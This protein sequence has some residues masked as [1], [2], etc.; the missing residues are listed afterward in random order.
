MGRSRPD[1]EGCLQ[2]D[3]KILIHGPAGATDK[4]SRS[5]GLQLR[6]A[7]HCVSEDIE[8]SFVKPG[9]GCV[10]KH[11][12]CDAPLSLEE[13]LHRFGDAQYRG[14]QQPGM[15]TGFGLPGD[16]ACPWSKTL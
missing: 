8:V 5:K 9:W 4:Q 10:I 7:F 12:G 14:T 11:C 16:V 1:E 6:L 15:S 13:K 3:A 2:Q